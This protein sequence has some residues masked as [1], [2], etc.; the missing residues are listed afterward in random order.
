VQDRNMFHAKWR[1]IRG[2]A[3]LSKRNL[4]GTWF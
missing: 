4:F 3:T 1:F 2:V